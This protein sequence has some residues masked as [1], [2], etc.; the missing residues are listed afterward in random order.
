LK[1]TAATSIQRFLITLL[2]AAA[3]GVG[4]RGTRAQHSAMVLR[5][6]SKG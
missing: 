2:S 5:V 4:A 1:A 3:A 6:F